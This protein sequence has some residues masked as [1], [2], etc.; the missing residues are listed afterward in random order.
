MAF[1]PF[2]YYKSPA[3]GGIVTENLEHYYSTFDSTSYPGT[4]KIFYDITEGS[5]P[6]NLGPHSGLDAAIEVT[7][8]GGVTAFRSIEEGGGLLSANAAYEEVITS[9]TLESW[10]YVET[11]TEF[12]SGN[13]TFVLYRYENNPYYQAYRKSD[14]KTQTYNLGTTNP[15]YY[16]STNAFS[17]NQWNHFVTTF[18]AADNSQYTYINGTLE[19]STTNNTWTSKTH[20]TGQIRLLTEGTSFRTTRGGIAIARIYVNK[21]LTSDEVTQNYN[22]ESP[23]F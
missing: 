20:N 23:L 15:G 12:N 1:I 3:E 6:L 5:N 13:G 4:G 16:A 17:R 10:A 22:A 14:N 21:A 9:L 18:N 19:A 8:L 11:G 7:T 2:G